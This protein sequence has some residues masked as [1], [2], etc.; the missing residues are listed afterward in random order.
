MRFENETH[1]QIQ[2]NFYE[3]NN[4]DTR[5]CSRKIGVEVD[6]LF[7]PPNFEWNRKSGRWRERKRASERK[8]KRKSV[9]ERV[10]QREKKS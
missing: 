8:R 1:C 2:L 10:R 5:E 4:N 3:E 9:S 7:I 6:I